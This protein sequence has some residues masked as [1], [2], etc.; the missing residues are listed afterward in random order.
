ME[1]TTPHVQA[2]AS[3]TSRV[4]TTLATINH[5]TRTI[6]L[7]FG[8]SI[9][10]N[11]T[12]LVHQLGLPTSTAPSIQVLFGDHQHLYHSRTQARCTVT[13]GN[14]TFSC[15]F[16]VLPYQLFP[17]TLVCD[18]F[19]KSRAMI[20]STSRQLLVPQAS[21]TP[22]LHNNPQSPTSAKSK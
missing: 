7:D 13:L 5:F 9:S 8:S 10:S 21:P 14:L 22:L 6:L 12:A 19:L 11:S 2:S 3:S 1:E 17:L 4:C 18:W 20:D 15:H 16:Y